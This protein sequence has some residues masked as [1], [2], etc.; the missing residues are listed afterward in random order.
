M[1]AASTARVR[2]WQTLFSIA[3]APLPLAPAP[4]VNRG[5]PGL[6]KCVPS[7][8]E[9]ILPTSERPL[10]WAIRSRLSATD[11][12][13]GRGN[14]ERASRAQKDKRSDTDHSHKKLNKNHQPVLSFGLRGEDVL[15]C[16]PQEWP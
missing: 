13:C 9:G 14:T 11:P 3:P 5:S 1:S 2:E 10:S 12:P 16:S 8:A 6:L 15:A 7:R 4:P